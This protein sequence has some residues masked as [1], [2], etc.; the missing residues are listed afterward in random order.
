MERPPARAASTDESCSNLGVQTPLLLADLLG[1]YRT[2]SSEVS[3]GDDFVL[4]IEYFNLSESYDSCTEH[5]YLPGSRKKLT[6]RTN[7]CVRA[8]EFRGFTSMAKMREGITA[9]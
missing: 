9:T 8:V 4:F 5:T 3:V 2:S 7:F 6:T 1:N